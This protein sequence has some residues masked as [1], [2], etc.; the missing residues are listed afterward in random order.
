MMNTYILTVLESIT[1]EDSHLVE[2][3]HLNSC[4]QSFDLT[5]TRH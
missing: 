1:P 4:K 5:K 3:F 2:K